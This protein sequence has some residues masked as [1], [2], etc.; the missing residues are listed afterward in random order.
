MDKNL[1]FPNILRSLE[2][3]IQTVQGKVKTIFETTYRNLLEKVKNVFFYLIIYLNDLKR[4]D[5]SMCRQALK[6]L[7]G[8]F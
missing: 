8:L 5:E 1:E 3:F 7:C 4:V 6:L 2:Q